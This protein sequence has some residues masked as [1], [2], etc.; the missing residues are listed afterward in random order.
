MSM[1]TNT[2][3]DFSQS[4][5]QMQQQKLQQASNAAQARNIHQ[6]QNIDKI[7][8]TAQEF[9]AVFLAQMF[10]HMFDGIKTDGPFGGGKGEEMFRGL[11]T[12]E[13][14]KEMARNGGI[15]LADD[16]ARRMIE[17]QSQMSN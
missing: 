1:I 17:L 14:G 15:G 2:A 10:N 11:L 8:E 3:T 5:G 7:K 6:P 16:V 13:Y 4:L 12:Q 9:E